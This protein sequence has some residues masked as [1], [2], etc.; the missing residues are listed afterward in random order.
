MRHGKILHTMEMLQSR[1]LSPGEARVKY[2]PAPHCFHHPPV[3]LCLYSFILLFT[4]PS[5]YT[6]LRA[7]NYV[8]A[9]AHPSIYLSVQA[10]VI[11]LST[12]PLSV[13]HLSVQ[14][15]L[16]TF[17]VFL[18]ICPPTPPA[19]HLTNLPRASHVTSPTLAPAMRGRLGHSPN[20]PSAVPLP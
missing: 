10:S 6:V 9:F 20:L 5:I 18:C 12:H 1:A 2:L 11:H 7:S 3:P 13:V 8:Y 17:T 4:C 15:S 14:P 19:I 16:Y